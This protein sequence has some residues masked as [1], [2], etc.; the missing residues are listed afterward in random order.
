MWVHV[1]VCLRRDKAER[2][3]RPCHTSVSQSKSSPVSS[4]MQSLMEFNKKGIRLRPMGK[5]KFLA[6]VLTRVDQANDFQ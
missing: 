5:C 1:C 3:A 2:L 6:D 4:H